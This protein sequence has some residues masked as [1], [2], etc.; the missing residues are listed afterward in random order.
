MND[1]FASLSGMGL[2]D[3]DA[4]FDITGTSEHVGVITESLKRDTRLVT[5]PYLTGYVHYG[6][7]ASSGASLKWGESM[8]GK[9]QALPCSG[10]ISDSPIFLPYLNGERAPIFDAD[11]K[12]VF[13]GID[14]DTDAAKMA[15]SVMEGVVFSAYHIY[16]T[17]GKP[18]CGKMIVSGGAADWEALNEL[19]AEM[20]QMP[21]SV[22]RE[23]ETSALG[24]VMAAA[25]GEGDY[26]DIA[27][28]AKA[29][30]KEEKRYLPKGDRREILM[31]R[32][33]IY[34]KL[35]PTLS[36]SFSCLKEVGK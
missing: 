30:C 13:F 8:F 36:E 21:L 11:A 12:G 6:V 19:K 3:A 16:E 29:F 31:K 1:F 32:Y 20:F 34:K 24:A 15:Y 5:G 14:A 28:A 35:Y 33:G 18:K 10:A 9:T 26:P 2:S 17:L 7:T 23:K 4:L 27:C 25:V 22:P